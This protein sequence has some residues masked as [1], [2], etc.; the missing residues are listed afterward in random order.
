MRIWGISDLHLAGGSNKSMDLFGRHWQ[1]HVGKMQQ[2][3]D[4]LVDV[5]DV[6]LC[7]GDLSWAMRLAQAQQDLQWIACRPGRKVLLRGNHDYWWS[8]LKQ[9]R[10]ALP[11]GCVALQN[12]SIDV[13]SWI[14]AGARGYD[15][16]QPQGLMSSQDRQIYERELVRLRL[17]LQHARQQPQPDKPLIVA[18]HYPPCGYMTQAGAK[19][20]F[21]ALLQE[22]GVKICVYGHLHGD[23]VQKL[24]VQGVVDGIAYHL[25]ACDWLQ[26]RPKLIAQC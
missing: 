15:L 12:D 16:P 23:S 17:S 13:G 9:V 1:D 11:A 19:D 2:A 22:F 25:I 20:D 7:P 5:D 21:V 26:F 18:M 14:V 3:W 8:S 24:A 6:V 4:E 10:A